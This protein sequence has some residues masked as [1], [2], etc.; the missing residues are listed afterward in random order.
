MRSNLLIYLKDYFAWPKNVRPAF[1]MDGQDIQDFIARAYMGGS[2]PNCVS[3]EAISK[4]V[5]PRTILPFLMSEV[6]L[7]VRVETLPVGGIVVP[8]GDTSG[9]LC[10]PV[11]VQLMTT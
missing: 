2:K 3:K 6:V 9:P 11:I 10:L 5:H 1:N 8:E 4:Y 7:P